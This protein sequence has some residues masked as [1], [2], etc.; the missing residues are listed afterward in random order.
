MMSLCFYRGP[1]KVQKILKRTRHN[2]T[3]APHSDAVKMFI[4]NLSENFK[5]NSVEKF[6][7]LV[8]RCCN[9]KRIIM[10]VEFPADH[11]VEQFGRLFLACLLKH[12]ELGKYI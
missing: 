4:T 12:H 11:P 3:H 5:D 9:V 6:L 7:S 8:K 2:T 1:K 10:P